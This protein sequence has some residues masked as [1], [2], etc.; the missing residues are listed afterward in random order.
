MPPQTLEQ[1]E[2]EIIK[3]IN[4]SQ[5]ITDMSPDYNLNDAGLDS[6]DTMDFCS[7]LEEKYG[8]DLTRLL[9]EAPTRGEGIET[10]LLENTY[11]T[12]RKI[13]EYIRGEMPVEGIA[14]STILKPTIA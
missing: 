1:I 5:G 13:A 11:L 10:E 2:S 14:P 7:D 8:V 3:M 12:P 9:N 4:D 6:L